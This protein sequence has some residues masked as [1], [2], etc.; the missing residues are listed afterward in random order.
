MV[1][2]R[3]QDRNGHEARIRDDEIADLVEEIRS[4]RARIERFEE[5][6]EEAK[7]RLRVLLEDRGE[8]W[9]DDDGYARLAAE[10]LR[11]YYDSGALDELII[12]DPLRYGWLKDYRKESAVPSR[13]QV[14]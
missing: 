10:G 13:V 2:E 11:R 3:L 4:N 9:S 7:E 1:Q 8:S 5:S 6:I 14:K 12:N